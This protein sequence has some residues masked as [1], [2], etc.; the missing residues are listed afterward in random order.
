MSADYT[1]SM[2]ESLDRALRRSKPAASA[3]RPVEIV[4]LL[5]KRP[6][7]R[8]CFPLAEQVDQWVRWSA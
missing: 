5:A 3:V 1:P 2:Q 4:H 6:E 8:E 7:V